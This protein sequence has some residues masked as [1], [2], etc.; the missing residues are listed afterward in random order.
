MPLDSIGT[1]L[2]WIGFP[3]FVLAMLAPDIS[4][5]TLV[6]TPGQ[7]RVVDGPDQCL[8]CPNQRS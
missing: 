4:R 2:L 3:V 8:L 5:G 7:P 6:L 1:P